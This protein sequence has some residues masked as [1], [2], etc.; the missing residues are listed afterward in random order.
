MHPRFMMMLDYWLGQPL[1]LLADLVHHI[2]KL[3][4]PK[5]ISVPLFKRVLFIELSEMG[6]AILAYSALLEACNKVGH[7]NVYFLI[8]ESN[9]ESVEI[10]NLLPKNNILTIDSSSLVRFGLTSV[11]ALCDVWRNRID[12]VMD[13][14]LFSRF[15]ALFSL[16]TFCRV[17]VGFHNF[18]SEGLYRGNFYTHPVSYNSHFHIALNFLAI[19]RAAVISQPEL[20]LLKQKLGQNLVDPAKRVYSPEARANIIRKLQSYYPE[21]NK[22]SVLIVL[23]PD[24]GPAIPIR[25]WP[26]ENYCGL[27]KKIVSEYGSA[28]ILVTGLQRASVLAQSICEACGPARCVDL[29]GKIKTLTELVDILGCSALVVSTDGGLAHFLT[30]TDTPGIV[31]FGPETPALYGPLAPNIRILFAN[32]HC[33]PC[34]KASN[35]RL[36]AC[37][38]N[39]CLREISV[40]DVFAHVQRIISQDGAK[41]ALKHLW[42][43]AAAELESCGSE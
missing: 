16:L 24:P 38:F 13:L 1:C 8:F 11:K 31:L 23:H 36:T 4:L 20:P 35:H 30:L 9:K 37:T 18:T 5:R 32:F 25:G 29:T 42:K 27:A 6:S 33:S 14:E 7:E 22:N 43:S 39:A 41:G 15:T 10:L 19:V 2:V 3:C 12:T 34:L 40:A 28:M 26:L 21:I 17:R